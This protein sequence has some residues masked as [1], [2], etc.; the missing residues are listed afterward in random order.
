[1]FVS[2]STKITCPCSTNDTSQTC[3]TTNGSGTCFGRSCSRKLILKNDGTVLNDYFCS[4]YEVKGDNFDRTVKYGR[5]GKIIMVLWECSYE[6]NCI[7]NIKNKDKEYSC[8]NAPLAVGGQKFVATECHCTEEGMK[9]MKLD[10]SL[11]VNNKCLLSSLHKGICVSNVTEGDSYFGC[12]SDEQFPEGFV[13]SKQFRNDETN[14]FLGFCADKNDCNENLSKTSRICEW[15]LI[16]ETN[17]ADF[18]EY[19]NCIII[20]ALF[21]SLF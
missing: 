1:M 16:E 13:E 20:L 15:P 19:F 21:I 11:C 2:V 12:T 6:S 5:S 3:V 10:P 8:F 9:T 4:D 7:L 14:F 17:E 18:A